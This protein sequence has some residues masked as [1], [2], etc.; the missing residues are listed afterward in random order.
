MLINKKYHLTSHKSTK[1]FIIRPILTKE[2]KSE[3]KKRDSKESLFDT[4]ELL[5]IRK[6]FIQKHKAFG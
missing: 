1:Y 2:M 6:N 4:I 3:Q 5:D